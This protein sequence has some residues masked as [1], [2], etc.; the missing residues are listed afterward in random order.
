MR[1]ALRTPNATLKVQ[2]L[3][4]RI[5]LAGGF[6]RQC[7]WFSFQQE[8]ERTKSGRAAMTP[9]KSKDS[10]TKGPN[11]LPSSHMS[12]GETSFFAESAIRDPKLF[13]APDT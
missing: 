11:T 8:P 9:G 1:A 7:F 5:F 2:G 12:A 6:N 13:G 3:G 10:T 4:F